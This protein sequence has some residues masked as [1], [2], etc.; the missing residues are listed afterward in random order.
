[1]DNGELF[2]MGIVGEILPENERCDICRKRK[3]KYLCDMPT[4][5]SKTLHIKKENGVTDYENSFKWHTHTC[6]KKICEECAVGLGG[7][8]HFCKDCFEKIRKM[9]YK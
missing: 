6:D 4:F 9:T 3:A 5:R 8:I 7:D 2:V 1:M